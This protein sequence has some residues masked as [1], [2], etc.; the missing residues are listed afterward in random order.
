MIVQQY[1]HTG[2]DVQRWRFLSLFGRAVYAHVNIFI[3]RRPK[4]SDVGD[5]GQF[6]FFG[7]LEDNIR[8]ELIYDENLLTLD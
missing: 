7:V 8:R 4:L 2:E 3:H 1:I 5:L 6:D